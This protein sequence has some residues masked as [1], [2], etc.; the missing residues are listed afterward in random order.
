MFENGISL[1]VLFDRYVSGSSTLC[2]VFDRYLISRAL[3]SALFDDS[4]KILLS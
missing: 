2:C 4:Y 1:F 3:C